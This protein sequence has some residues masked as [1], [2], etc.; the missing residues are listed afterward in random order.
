MVTD[1]P[2][3]AILERL[4]DRIVAIMP[5]TAAGVTLISPGAGPRFVAASDASRCGSNNYS[6]SSEK[7]RALRPMTPARPSQWRT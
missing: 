5:I 4:V 1:F 6:P 2:I 7:G 3:Q